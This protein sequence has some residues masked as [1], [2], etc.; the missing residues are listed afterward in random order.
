LLLKL[1]AEPNLADQ[2]NYTALHEAAFLGY[3]KVVEILIKVKADINI[4]DINSITPLGYAMRSGGQE[5]IELL[6]HNGAHL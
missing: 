4:R 6:E 5:V 1:G 2:Y 3:P